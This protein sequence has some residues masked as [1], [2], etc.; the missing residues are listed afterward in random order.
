MLNRKDLR[1]NLGCVIPEDKVKLA[2]PLNEVHKYLFL[3]TQKISRSM[4]MGLKGPTLNKD[5]RLKEG[6]N[7]E[8]QSLHPE[9]RS[10]IF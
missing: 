4:V 10:Y 5:R 6:P 1:F 8:N 9:N 2:E 3:L 7:Q